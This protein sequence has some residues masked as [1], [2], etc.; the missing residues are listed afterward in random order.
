MSAP[1]TESEIQKR[2][3]IA[4]NLKGKDIFQ[5][6]PICPHCLEPVNVLDEKVE[7]KKRLQE[8]GKETYPV[9]EPFCPWC[10]HLIALKDFVH[11]V[12]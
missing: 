7:V 5:E 10:G 4:M 3:I 1:K 11:L 2:L 6:T 8:F 12:H 9:L